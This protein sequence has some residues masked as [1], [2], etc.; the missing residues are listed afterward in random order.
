MNEFDTEP[1]KKDMRS[2]RMNFTKYF[3][4]L[5]GN[6]YQNACDILYNCMVFLGYLFEFNLNKNKKWFDEF[7]TSLG[8]K[9]YHEHLMLVFRQLNELARLIDF[10]HD[11]FGF[12]E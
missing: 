12:V 10:S 8:E 6:Q 9:Y 11:I 5:Q 3:R 1:I 4:T 2:I 7:K